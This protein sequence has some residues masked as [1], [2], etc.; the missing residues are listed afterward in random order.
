[1]LQYSSNLLHLSSIIHK[2]TELFIQEENLQCAT[3]PA[4]V[5]LGK[6]CRGSLRGSAGESACKGS[7][8]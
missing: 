3:A 1:M 5:G 7:L 4:A 2:C 8:P 6:L